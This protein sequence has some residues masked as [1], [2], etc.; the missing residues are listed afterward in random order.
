MMSNGPCAQ[1][2]CGGSITYTPPAGGGS[3][4][5]GGSSGGGAT[6]IPPA[7]GGSGSG[8]G[9][10]S[11][12]G[13][14]SLV[15]AAKQEQSIFNADFLSIGLFLIAAYL[16]VLYVAMIIRMI[17]GK[18][19][20]TKAQ[21]KQEKQI[22]L[23]G[24]V[25]EEDDGEPLDDEENEVDE[26]KMRAWR[27]DLALIVEEL[28]EQDRAKAEAENEKIEEEQK[29]TETVLEQLEKNSKVPEDDD[30]EELF[31]KYKKD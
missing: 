3:G 26:E 1:S 19:M 15:E 2:S 22:T 20:T 27:E 24:R 16:V 18:R 21:D 28:D 10:G 12:T 17:K 13:S 25:V 9:S 23:S 31:N 14:S 8:S 29:Q 5:G 6:Y 30:W 11:S 4:L 7:G